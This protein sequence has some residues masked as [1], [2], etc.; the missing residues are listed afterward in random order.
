MSSS[1]GDLMW[2]EPTNIVHNTGYTTQTDKPWARAY[3]PIENLL[4]HSSVLGDGN[5]YANFE[6]AMLPLYDDDV[7][8]LASPAVP[9]NQ[10]VWR[11]DT[12]ADCELWFHTEISNVV[13]AAWNECREI[14]QSSH[15]KPPSVDRISEEVDST[16][17]VKLNMDRTVLVIGEMKR[18]LL[19]NDWWQKGDLGSAPG[20]AKLSKE[21]RGYADKSQ[22]PQVFCFDGAT[23]LL[24][25]FRANR[26]EDIKDARRP[27]DCWALPTSS[28]KA[29]LRYA[30][31][32]LLVQ[33]FRRFQGMC[34]MPISVGGLTPLGRQ[35]FNGL[36]VWKSEVDGAEVA[37]VD[38]PGGY[39]R[40][41][42]AE[43]GAVKWTHPDDADDVVWET[44][45]L[46]GGYGQ[47]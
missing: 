16:Y 17:T 27:V 26:P 23:L 43:S 45:A 39:Q 2:A 33:G 30:L 19:R 31:Y 47:E 4:V 14:T 5:T 13:L 3:P 37:V 29:P 25:Q 32:R 44:P 35:F 41:V 36:P 38:H 11:L 1:I 40:S 12:E 18:N 21:L 24:L 8:R 34:A 9:P 20:Q 28:S 15:I 42:D 22:C 10:R 6:P 46:W 7:I